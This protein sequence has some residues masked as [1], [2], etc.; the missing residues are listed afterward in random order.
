[1][2][3]FVRTTHPT[4][5]QELVRKKYESVKI[6]IFTKMNTTAKQVTIEA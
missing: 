2:L 1:M 3:P 4:Y 6:I 5:L